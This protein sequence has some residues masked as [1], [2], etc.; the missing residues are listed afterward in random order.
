MLKDPSTKRI[1]IT[2]Y[3]TTSKITKNIIE[4]FLSKSLAITTKIKKQWEYLKLEK[5]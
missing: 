3:N 5:K 4:A 1:K 2:I